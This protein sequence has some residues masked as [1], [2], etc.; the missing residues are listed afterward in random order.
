MKLQ[1][2]TDKHGLVRWALPTTFT[3]LSTYAGWR[4]LAFL[5]CLVLCGATWAGPPEFRVGEDEKGRV[6][7]K[8][9]A[10]GEYVQYVPRSVTP[11]FRMAVL[12]H[13]MLGRDEDAGE[14]AE[15]F[16]RRWIPAGER[17]GIILLAPAFDQRNFGGYRG[18]G[19]GYRGLFGREIGADEFVNEIVDQYKALSPKYDGRFYLYGHSAGGQFVSRY[20][21]R[22][23]Q[24]IIAAVISAAGTYAFPNPDVPWADGMAPLVRSMRWEGGDE[25]QHI[26]IQP[27]PQGWIKAAALPITVVVGSQDT[28]ALK[29]IGGQ[30]GGTRLERARHWVQD[31]NR[32]A[33]RLDKTG[34]GRLVVVDGAAHSSAQLTP[35]CVQHLFGR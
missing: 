15:R 13:G 12:V 2:D 28:E 1:I 22:H 16:I 8:A 11:Q 17:L 27:D 6:V 24:R 31:M 5:F 18:P 20:V 7:C 9:T 10:H 21:V 35:T 33:Q 26:D 32:L 25:M 30:K 3:D 4:P 14:V 19:G 29:G 34:R 23:P